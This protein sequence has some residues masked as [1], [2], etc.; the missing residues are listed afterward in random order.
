MICGKCEQ[1]VKPFYGA[2]FMLDGVYYHMECF[3]E[4]D[5]GVTWIKAGYEVATNK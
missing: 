2:L 5:I 4:P 3:P 1:E